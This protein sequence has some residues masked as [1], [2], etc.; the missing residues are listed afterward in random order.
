[1]PNW[2]STGITFY[3]E[4]EEQIKKFQSKL[5]DIYNIEPTVENGFGHG[6]LGDYA[7][8]FFPEIGHD[9]I[10]CRGYVSYI[11]EDIFEREGYYHFAICTETAWVAMIGLW[12]EIV[13]RFYGGVKIAYIAEE[14]G[15]DYFEKWDET[16]LFYPT[17]MYVDCYYPDKNGEDEYIDD[18]AFDTISEVIDWLNNNVTQFEHTRTDNLDAL[19]KET[20]DGLE[21][22]DGDYYFS[23]SWYKNSSPEDFQFR[24]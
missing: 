5:R 23:A 9:K 2:C 19:E 20:Q 21:K 10:E 7:N 3:S 14:C 22:L 6:W 18:H 4:N 11:D 15:M 8:T 1:M 17:E 16:G 13:N 12:R 24:K